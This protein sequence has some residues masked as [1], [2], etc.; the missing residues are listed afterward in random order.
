MANCVCQGNDLFAAVFIYILE[1]FS[2][3]NLD[4]KQNTL[5]NLNNNVSADP[6]WQLTSHIA[7][8]SVFFNV[9]VE[10]WRKSA[11][12]FPSEIHCHTN[13]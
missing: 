11:L 3:V 4:W 9:T 10:V 2:F 8:V 13:S 5:S 7:S 1:M 12:L 6:C